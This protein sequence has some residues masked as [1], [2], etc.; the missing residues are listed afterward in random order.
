MLEPELMELP[1]GGDF[2]PRISIVLIKW[3]KLDD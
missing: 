3:A 2:D 1:L